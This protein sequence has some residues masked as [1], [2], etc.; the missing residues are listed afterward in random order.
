MIGTVA[1]PIDSIILDGPIS[2]DGTDSGRNVGNKAS[3][4]KEEPSLGPF[5]LPRKANITGGGGGGGSGGSIIIFAS[6]VAASEYGLVS[7]AGGNA[8]QE[9]GGGGGGGRVHF[10]YFPLTSKSTDPLNISSVYVDAGLGSEGGMNG[11]NGSISS[12]ACPPGF[13]GVFCARCPLGTYKNQYG[14][15]EDLCEQCP[16]IPAQAVYVFKGYGGVDRTPCPY[17]CVSKTLASE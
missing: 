5:L 13:A 3:L 4:G 8:L 15:A 14:Y 10:D 16:P 17:K 2:A 11:G 9:G 1:L 12:V 7:T 6:E